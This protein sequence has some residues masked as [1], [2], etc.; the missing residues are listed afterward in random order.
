M[1][2]T[3]AL[4]AAHA[5]SVDFSRYTPAMI[6]GGL[7]EATTVRQWQLE[8][9]TLA[10]ARAKDGLGC[11]F[12]DEQGCG[13]TLE[14]IGLVCMLRGLKARSPAVAAMLNPAAGDGALVVAPTE[15]IAAQIRAEFQ[16][17]APAVPTLLYH[18]P[19]RHAAFAAAASSSLPAV[20]IT[21]IHVVVAD[22]R[23]KAVPKP[24]SPLFGGMIFGA[25]LIDEAHGLRGGGVH[26]TCMLRAIRTATTGDPAGARPVVVLATGTPINTDPHRELP[27]LLELIAPQL[28][29]K[30]RFTPSDKKLAG[31]ALAEFVRRRTQLLVHLR[32]NFFSRRLRST[33]WTDLPPKRTSTIELELGE[34]ELAV[35]A[36]LHASYKMSCSRFA[37]AM[38]GGNLGKIK[39]ALQQV[40]LGMVKLVRCA[41]DPVAYVEL[42]ATG[43][44]P[45]ALVKGPTAKR[46]AVVA[47]LKAMPPARKVCLFARSTR[48]LDLYAGSIAAAAPEVRVLRIDGR[49]PQVRRAAVVG[50]F[51]AGD[52]DDPAM[53]SVL[54][55]TM[56][57]CGQGLN[58]QF[59]SECIFVDTWPNPAVFEQ[60][61][62]RLHRPGQ[63]SPVNIV[64]FSYKGTV[65]AA[66]PR[67]HELR[68]GWATTFLEGFGALT[69]EVPAE[70]EAP[71]ELKSCCSVILSE[72]TEYLALSGRGSGEA[73]ASAVELGVARHPKPWTSAA[74]AHPTKRLKLQSS[75]A[76]SSGLS[77]PR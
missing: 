64:W 2:E 16:R 39:Q 76:S 60:A 65:E 30:G 53:V 19:G 21:T 67:I 50:A 45:A 13:K 36:A 25:V 9:I 18:G 6:A 72:W 66:M 52:P 3:R 46:T 54:L 7:S 14:M 4:S 77:R 68:T 59:A 55:T 12:A 57:T 1:E 20:I 31:P 48:V 23:S 73:A 41:S 61:E 15:L 5:A 71:E 34:D 63:M 47:A 69:G 33:V 10:M 44:A 40:K 42:K 37:Q 56:Q 51:R 62:A 11:F 29:G 70:V 24:A 74:A 58:L 38:R 49:V 28:S 26:H 22:A 32:Q 35:Y 27:L 43:K 8:A 17:F 75:A